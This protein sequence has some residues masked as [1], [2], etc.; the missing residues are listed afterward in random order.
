MMDTRSYIKH[1]PP[2]PSVSCP[3]LFLH[4][5]L[6]LSINIHHESLVCNENAM[7]GIF[8]SEL[9]IELHNVC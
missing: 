3:P 1:S 2:P 5:H 8:I 4:G 7:Y 9:F 6:F